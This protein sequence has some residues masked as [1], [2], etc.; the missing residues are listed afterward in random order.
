MKQD[1]LSAIKKGVLALK[2]LQQTDG[3]FISYSSGRQDNFSNAIPYHATFATSLILLTAKN[4]RG[5]SNVDKV[6]KEAVMFLLANKSPHWSWNYWARNSQEAKNMPY[7][8]DLDDTFCALS[9]LFSFD[10][11]LI[12]GFVM[13]YV[14][15]I[16]TAAEKEEGGPYRTWLVG[17]KVD[18]KW[19]D[20]DVVVNTNIAY[21]LYLQDINLPGLNKFI[22]TN[23]KENNLVSQY[24]PSFYPTIYFL[25]RFY[26]GRY[27]KKLQNILLQHMDTDGSF[28]NPLQTALAISALLQFG[29]PAKNL[30]KNV[31]Y[32][33]QKQKSG[34]WQPFAFCIDPAQQGKTYYAG[35]T[36]LTTAF[37]LEA[38]SL[39]QKFT[40]TV[41]SAEKDNNQEKLIEK[42]VPILTDHFNNFD[43][44]VK[45][46]AS[47]LMEN[48]LKGDKD[49]QITL[50][51]Y[52]FSK[53]LKKRKIKNDLVIKLGV[54][55][56]LGWIAYTVYDDFFDEEGNVL[57]LSVANTALR[58]L[59][60]IYD[61]LLPKQKNFIEFFH[62]IM[63]RLDCSNAWEITHCRIK[64]VNGKFDINNVPVPNFGKDNIKIAE[65]SI[66]HAL[67]PLAILFSLGFTADSLEIKN[68]LSFFTHFL[69]AKQ[70]NDDAHD[71]EED[72]KRGHITK[73]V[74]LL[75]S[76][77]KKKKI[78]NDGEITIKKILP[79]LQELF[80]HEIIQLVCKDILLHVDKAENILQQCTFLDD[81]SL[82]KQLLK[83]PKRA[84]EK[85]LKEQKDMLEFLQTYQPK[86]E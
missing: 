50:L 23:I 9:A 38:L 47:S 35:A 14:V 16:L 19:K 1:I 30:E 28:E 36:A 75:L 78:I 17:E 58:G 77:A 66:G 71:W 13:G 29:F 59:T 56:L 33:L 37:C 34:T 67:S 69:I 11:S 80:W 10:P 46:Q 81:K 42:I 3:S 4:I 27:T 83:T 61:T 40:D 85:A 57:L 70:L 48:L 76:H 2:K 25:S 5:S 52:Y 45:Q 32:L 62:I 8:D 60:K 18:E 7:P 26:K 44:K 12:D 54:A 65:K 82:L 63:D 15:S 43:S 51:P 79:Q 84:A 53:T 64:V 55:N 39:Y 22:N 68:M 41:L 20:I 86:S 24:Y 72:L 49:H 6:K 74:G 73:V 31:M 21:F